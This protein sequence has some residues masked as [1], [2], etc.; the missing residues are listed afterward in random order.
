[1]GRLCRYLF[2][3]FCL[4]R[5]GYSSVVRILDLVIFFAI[6]GYWCCSYLV[7]F[8][9]RFLSFILVISP[10]LCISFYIELLPAM[11]LL[12]IYGFV[13]YFIYLLPFFI[14]FAIIE[15]F[16][17]DLKEFE[18]YYQFNFLIRINSERT[19]HLLDLNLLYL[20]SKRHKY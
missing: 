17:V 6:M 15:V 1:M 3:F 19:T 20:L 13:K 12:N 7:V 5:L 11:F 9:V 14:F 8:R 16:G 4:Y 2:G 10:I 18:D